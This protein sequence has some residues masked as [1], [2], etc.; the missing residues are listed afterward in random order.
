MI[1]TL[2]ALVGV[3]LLIGLGNWQRHRLVWKEGLI[4]ALE[5]RLAAAP[6]PLA[7]PAAWKDLGADDE[8]LRVSAEVTFLNDKEALV[9]TS[10][11]S[12]R[13]DVNGPGYWVFTPAR[14]ADGALVMV[15]RGFVPPERREP[16]SR[17]EGEVAGAV[18]ITA[19][20]RWPDPAS[21]FTPAASPQ[22]NQWFSRDPA[23]IAAAKG[24]GEVA[25]FYL[26]QEGPDPP[27]GLP[28][29]G[30]LYPSL[31]NS[32]FGYMLTWYGLAL[33]LAGVYAAWLARRLRPA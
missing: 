6:V 21:V 7:P 11:S 25:P 19:A 8:Y 23:A 29:P 16:A 9:Y 3:A 22:S 14:L 28:K 30:R 24:V 18:A 4:A 10:G 33:A 32:H 26:E 15:D 13:H 20:L 1:P 5:T 2:F 31:P 12:L 17:R 27:G